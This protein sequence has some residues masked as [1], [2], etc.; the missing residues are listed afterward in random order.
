MILRS[1]KNFSSLHA[2]QKG[3][4]RSKVTGMPRDGLG[5]EMMTEGSKRKE[6]W[7]EDR[8]AFGIFFTEI[9]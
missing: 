5:A 6:K 3:G 9:L 8:E 4:R 7:I 1:S 2:A